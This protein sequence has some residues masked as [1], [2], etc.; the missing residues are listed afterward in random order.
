MLAE[1]DGGDILCQF[2]TWTAC[3]YRD[4]FNYGRSCKAAL[5][6]GIAKYGKAALPTG[7]AKYSKAALPTGIAK[8]GKA[9]SL[10]ESPATP[11]SAVCLSAV[12]QL[13]LRESPSAAS[14]LPAGI[15]CYTC[16]GVL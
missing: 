9:L 7:I 3:P 2:G 16:A 12:G 5:P 11:A 15:V 10:R 14:T 1:E 4:R 8:C 13:S 6:A